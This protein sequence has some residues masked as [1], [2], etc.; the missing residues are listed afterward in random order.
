MIAAA[1]CM[2]ICIQAQNANRSGFFIELEGGRAFG[3]VMDFES[4]SY[5]AE[6]T[7]LKDGAVGSLHFGYRKTTSNSVAI[8]AKIGAWTN[9]LDVKNTLNVNIMPGIR[10]TSKEFTGNVSAFLSFN[11]GF[12]L[13]KAN[14]GCFYVPVEIGVGLNLTNN[15]YLGL[16]ASERILV[17]SYYDSFYGYDYELDNETYGFAYLYPKSYMSAGLRLGFRF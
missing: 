16:F 7:Y 17:S 8:E 9:F 12:G 4:R 11:A 14:P 15:L 5:D 3:N 2:A 10:W 6:G 13:N 1:I